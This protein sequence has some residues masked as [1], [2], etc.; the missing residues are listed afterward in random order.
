[1][2]LRAS[3][4]AM[5]VGMSAAAAHE[6]G[7][8]ARDRG[9][10][11]GRAPAVCAVGVGALAAALLLAG[12]SLGPRSRETESSSQPVSA[13]SGLDGGKSASAV[14]G[15]GAGANGGAAGGTAAGGGAGAATVPVTARGKADFERAVG[16]MK[17]G[18][19]TEAELEFKQV[20]LQYPQLSAP[21]VNL[22][23]LYRKTGRLDQSEA[24]LKTAVE[25]N[26]G[27]AVA[28]TELGATQRLRGEFPS[29]AA[30]YE[31]AIAADP[32][33]APAYR[34]L[35]VVSDLYL[36]DPERALTA[37]ERYKELSGEEKPV[38]GWIAELR[39]RT[40]KPPLKRPA[41]TPAPGASE[42][43]SSSGSGAAADG[44]TAAAGAGASSGAAGGAAN[45]VVPAEAKPTK[46]TEPAGN[47]A[48]PKGGE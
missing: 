28:W 27:S 35:G 42:G 20:A 14:T 3:T 12:C 23:I 25:H 17:A 22:G 44:G 7:T 40:G 45:G 33:F 16:A 34:N 2:W 36:G 6:D 31:K 1:M 29:A 8:R 24:A 32:N 38:S 13:T 47:T 26:D 19:T 9:V 37:F 5:P 10:R 43:A 21:Y 15:G 39:Q 11:A 41:T 18:N 30:S 4:D 46:P 48:S